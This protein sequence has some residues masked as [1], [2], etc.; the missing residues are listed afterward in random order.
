MFPVLL[1][2][3]FW[4]GVQSGEKLIGP[5]RSIARFGIFKEWDE[6]LMLVFMI[7]YIS[8]Y[9]IKMCILERR[10]EINVVLYIHPPTRSSPSPH[11]H[12]Y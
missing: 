9:W 4:N 7:T 11:H 3:G 5:Y 1:H 6:V 2:P 12:N 8:T 10:V